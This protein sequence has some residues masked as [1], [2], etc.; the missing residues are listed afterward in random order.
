MDR[1]QTKAYTDH[2]EK[3][4]QAAVSYAPDK[5]DWF[6]GRWAGLGRPD[7]PVLG[8]RNMPP[9]SAKTRLRASGRC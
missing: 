7:E 1:P 3:E 4:F 6:E 8:R 9:R 2:L 5:A